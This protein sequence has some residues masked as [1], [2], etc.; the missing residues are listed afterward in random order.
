MRQCT[1][2]DNRNSAKTGCHLCSMML[3]AMLH[4]Q[5]NGTQFKFGLFRWFCKVSHTYTIVT[6][7]NGGELDTKLEI[8]PLST[9]QIAQ[10]S[11]RI[12]RLPSLGSNFGVTPL[13]VAR[14]L[15]QVCE[16][17]HTQCRPPK[18]TSTPW[19]QQ[20]K[21]IRLISIRSQDNGG[22]TYRLIKQPLDE[23]VD[24]ITFSYRWTDDVEKNMLWRENTERFTES[25]QTDAGLNSIVMRPPTCLRV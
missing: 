15:L 2:K 13:E 4:R 11:V 16:H 8:R 22:Q 19:A 6:F 3:H 20:S 9:F 7:L 24:Y 12:E 25:T 18:S 14:H 10:P 5:P 17:N 21:Y 1:I 23:F